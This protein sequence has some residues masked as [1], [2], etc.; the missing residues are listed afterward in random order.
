MKGTPTDPQCGFSRQACHIL[1]DNKIKYS[2]F[3]VL[4]DQNIREQLKKHSNWNTYPQL[5]VDGELIGGLDIMKQMIENGEFDLKLNQQKTHEKEKDMKKYL[6]SLINQ[7]PL[8]LFIKGTAETPRCGFTKELL[9]LLD[10]ANIK[11]FKTFDI[12]QDENVRQKLKEYS[13]WQTYPQVYVNGQFV[14]GLDILKQMNEEGTLVQ[15]LKGNQGL[16]V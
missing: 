14:G 3:D 12:L 2:T 10:N 16:A 15:T 4:S 9:N 11:D 8:M 1:D 7:A 6:E 5:F 13:S